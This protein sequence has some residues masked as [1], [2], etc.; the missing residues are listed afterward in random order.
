M[1]LFSE[2]AT[3]ELAN[4]RG[5]IMKIISSIITT[6]LILNTIFT[7]CN[8]SNT[9]SIQ[10]CGYSDSLPESAHKLEFDDWS[11][12]AFVD[13]KAQQKVS[14]TVGSIRVKGD[15]VS[16]EQ[17]YAEFFVTHEYKDENNRHFALTDDGKLCYYF[18]GNNP[19]PDEN[20]PIYA[21]S[22]CIE[23][24]S[25]YLSN[26]TDISE[27]TVTADYNESNKMYIVSFSKYADGFKCAD[28]AEIWIEETGHIYSFFSTML[29]RI[30]SNAKT[31][32]DRKVI[33]EQIIAKLDGEYSKVKETYDKVTYEN[34][35]YELTVDEEGDY[36][37]ICSVDVNCIDTI[38]GY[39]SVISERIRLLIQQ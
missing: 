4:E 8:Q 22:E 1:P 6:L 12:D 13:S 38:D 37:L 26:L 33:Q 15:Y 28:Q 3:T 35:S 36:A 10:I 16:S 18:F 20:A 29:G 2:M 24:A 21:E 25:A 9:L 5:T 34:F 32:F 23:M 27:Y 30:P 31:G 11:K 7:G 17:R 39:D 19:S 14:F